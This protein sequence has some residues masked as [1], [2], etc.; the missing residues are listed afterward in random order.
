MWDK[1]PEDE[2]TAWSVEPKTARSVQH[3]LIMRH[4]HDDPFCRTPDLLGSSQHTTP[5]GL[6]DMPSARSNDLIESGLIVDLSSARSS[7]T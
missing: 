7:V 3:T 4:A 6:L 1:V 5:H 2:I